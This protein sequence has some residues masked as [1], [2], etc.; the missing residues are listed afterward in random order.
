MNV[1]FFG[2]IVGAEAAACVAERLPGLRAELAVDLAIINAENCAGSGLGMARKQVEQILQ[3]GADVITGGNH[4]W[5]TPESVELLSNTHVIRP[6][7]V[8]VDIP[9]RGILSVAVG[10]QEIT[11]INLADFCAMKSVK[12]IKNTFYPA[13]KC[14]RDS[15]KRGVVIVDYHGD[16]VLEKQIFAHA[17]DGEATAVIGTHTHEP[18]SDLHILPHGTAFVTDA[19]MIGPGGGVQG[20]DPT[21]L[22]AGLRAN[23]DP[24]SGPMPAVRVGPV[25]GEAILLEISGSLTKSIRRVSV[26]PG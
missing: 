20:F 9:G 4:S 17:V 8:G 26:V 14:W 11:V 18:T 6:N 21:C 10:S 23:G 12:A 3:A 16:H 25:T 2:D 24:F 13:Y 1:L 22:V 7:N 5:D 15:E 19:G